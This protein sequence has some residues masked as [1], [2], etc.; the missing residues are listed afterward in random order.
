[1]NGMARKKAR[2]AHEA[3]YSDGVPRDPRDWTVE[4]WNDLY[5]AM[6]WLK[7]RVAKRHA[8]KCKESELGGEG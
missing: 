7:R 2:K 4:D 5:K 1:M 6:E 3:K 8:E